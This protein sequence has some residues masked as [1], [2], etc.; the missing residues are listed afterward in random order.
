MHRDLKPD[1]VLLTGEGVVKLADF[2]HAGPLIDE[3][4]FAAAAALD[5]EEARAAAAASASAS[6]G[7]GAGAGAGRRGGKGGMNF[8]SL[9]LI[10]WRKTYALATAA[11]TS[12]DFQRVLN[13]GHRHWQE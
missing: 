4:D 1:N 10:H 9:A 7:A 8:P 6:A 13:K 11:C 5:E 3:R 12:N 2:G